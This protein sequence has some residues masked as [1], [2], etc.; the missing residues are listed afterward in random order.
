MSLLYLVRHA[1]SVWTPDEQRPLSGQGLLAA[2][3]VARLLRALPIAAV[4]SSSS[5]RALQTV[6]PLAAQLRLDVRER[7]DLV[8]RRLAAQP[9]EDF[10]AALRGL[11]AQPDRALPGGESNRS[12]QRRGVAAVRQIAQAHPGQHVAVATHGNLMALI[13]QHHDP[14]VDFEFWQRLSL[15]DVY[16]LDLSAQTARPPRRLWPG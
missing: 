2:Q 9:V 6:R 7:D 10:M 3:D 8:E 5:L 14:A 12:A 15:P 16:R 1:H 11:W 13:L 4:Y